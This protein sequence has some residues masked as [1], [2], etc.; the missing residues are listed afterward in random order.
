M[1]SPIAVYQLIILY[2]LQRCGGEIA[3]PHLSN[4]LIENGYV[5]FESLVSTYN[6]ARDNGFVT[7]RVQ[8]DTTFLQITEE[9]RQTWK[10]F[11]SQLSPAIQ[12]QADEY[13]ESIGRQLV[14][15]RSIIGEYYK[16]SYGGYLAHMAVKEDKAVLLEIN[17]NVPSE[18]SA[19]AVI[20][21]WREQSSELYQELISRLLR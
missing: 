14:S 13:L 4:F 1:E 7:S 19:K 8:G 5:N 12:K 18:E 11:R 6:E 16:A 2:I 15:D 10:F 20:Q 21:R 9:G 3:M 17:L